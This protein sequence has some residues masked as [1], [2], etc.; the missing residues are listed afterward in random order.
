[1]GGHTGKHQLQSGSREGEQEE[2]REEPLIVASCEK[3]R[4]RQGRLA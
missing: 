3:E 2:N 1:M 4:G